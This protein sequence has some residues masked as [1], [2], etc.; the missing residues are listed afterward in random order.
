MLMITTQYVDQHA[1]VLSA[2]SL[3]HESAIRTLTKDTYGSNGNT[4]TVVTNEGKLTL[5]MC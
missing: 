3:T 5:R 4:H 1:R 2:A